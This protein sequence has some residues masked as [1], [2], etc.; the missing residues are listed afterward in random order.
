MSRKVAKDISCTALKGHTSF[1]SSLAFSPNGKTLTSGDWDNTICL[2]NTATGEHRQT[3]M[4][5]T[6]KLTSLSFSPDGMTLAR[7]SENLKTILLWDAMTGKRHG[8][9]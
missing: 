7:A 9:L 5:H 4:G 2:W 1:V 3:L 8:T 6:R